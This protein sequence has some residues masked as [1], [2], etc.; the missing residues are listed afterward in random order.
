M[1]DSLTPLY[2][3]DGLGDRNPH[4]LSD[5]RDFTTTAQQTCLLYAG[6]FDLEPYRLHQIYFYGAVFSKTPLKQKT[7]GFEIQFSL[8]ERYS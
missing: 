3:M 5:R 7:K 6:S 1:V 2:H 8:L 4:L